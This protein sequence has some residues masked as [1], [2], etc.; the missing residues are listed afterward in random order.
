MPRVSRRY[1]RNPMGCRPGDD[2]TRQ[3]GSPGFDLLGSEL[4]EQIEAGVQ[5]GELL[6]RERDELE[7]TGVVA[8]GHVVVDEA[9]EIVRASYAQPAGKHR[10]ERRDQLAPHEQKARSPG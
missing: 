4:E 3:R 2:S 6:E 5:T 7:A 8:P 1:H 9:R 10:L